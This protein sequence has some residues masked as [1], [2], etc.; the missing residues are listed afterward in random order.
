[1]EVLIQDAENSIHL[2][3]ATGKIKW[4]KQLEGPIMVKVKQIDVYS[5]NKWQMLFNTPAK[6]NLIDINGNEVKGF[7]IELKAAASN[8]VAVLS[9]IHIS[10]PT[11]P[12]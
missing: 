4:S 3:S 8:P 11:R 5:N 2:I 1:M 10:E 6:I 9:L 12:Y 7:P